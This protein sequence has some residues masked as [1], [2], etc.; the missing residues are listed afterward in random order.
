[1][2]QQEDDGD[3]AFTEGNE[4]M[5]QDLPDDPNNFFR[6]QFQDA[7]DEQDRKRNEREM[8]A[9]EQQ[10]M[11]QEQ[12]KLGGNFLRV[13]D[14]SC[15]PFTPFYLMVSGHI[16]SGTLNDHDGINCQFDF[17]AGVDWQ[18]H[19]VSCSLLVLRN[20]GQQSRSLAACIQSAPNKQ[21]SGVEFP[22]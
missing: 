5:R 16:Q 4:S 9:E 1:M 6:P 14:E 22:I 13:R 21:K 7:I 12:M 18:L 11:R 10:E 2:M 19:S 15:P 20:L 3:F 8:H 17:M